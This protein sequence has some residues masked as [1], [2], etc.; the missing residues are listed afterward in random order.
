VGVDALGIA[1]IVVYK[2]LDGVSEIAKL[3]LEKV[4]RQQV[5]TKPMAAQE[6]LGWSFDEAV[7]RVRWECPI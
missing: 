5:L 6:C 2:K 7:C 3:T 4:L 1:A